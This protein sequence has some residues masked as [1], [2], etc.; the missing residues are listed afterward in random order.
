MECANDICNQKMTRGL[1]QNKYN[2]QKKLPNLFISV[3]DHGSC[4]S[5]NLSYKNDS[6]RNIYIF[7]N[8]KFI[9]L[10]WFLIADEFLLL[11]FLDFLS[12][13]ILVLFSKG[14]LKRVWKSCR[15]KRYVGT[16]FWKVSLFITLWYVHIPLEQIKVRART[17][18]TM[19][20][21]SICRCVRLITLNLPHVPQPS[22]IASLSNNSNFALIN[23][24]TL[25]WDQKIKLIGYSNVQK[26]VWCQ[27][28]QFL[29]AIWIPDSPTMDT[30]LCSYELVQYLNGQPCT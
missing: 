6:L 5:L 8:C 1:L 26:G 15:A 25:Q 20:A 13:I 23:V 17:I 22:F 10:L 19:P 14:L 21:L 11:S 28:V 30:I 7:W 18:W 16:C 9:K 24:T 3:F 4:G 29:N 12:S 2:I 27:M